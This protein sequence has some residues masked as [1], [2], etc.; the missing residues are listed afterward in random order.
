MTDLA[1]EITRRALAAR[2][3]NDAGIN[4]SP[5]DVEWWLAMN[6]RQR[7]E[8]SDRWAIHVAMS[9]ITART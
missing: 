6:P 7:Q 8:A 4:A 9:A 5:A 2:Q 1:D 3:L